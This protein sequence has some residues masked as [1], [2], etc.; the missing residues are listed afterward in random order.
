[1][2]GTGWALVDAARP[3][4][5]NPA[6]IAGI[7]GT[8]SSYGAAACYGAPFNAYGLASCG[9]S[10]SVPAFHSWRE[11]FRFMARFLTSRWPN[12]RTPFDFYGYAADPWS[13]GAHTAAHMNEL[14]FQ[15]TVRW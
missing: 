4:H 13:W 12:A 11:S 15:A 9:R 3:Y 14:G 2:A 6:L 7:A 8:E 1:M 5:L 10:W